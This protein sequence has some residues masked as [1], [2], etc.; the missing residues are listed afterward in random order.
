MELRHLRYFVAVAEEGQ[1]T[2]AARRLCMQQPPLSQQL[3]ELEREIGVVLFRR[4]ARG[5]ELTDAG[6]V[7]LAEA[8]TLLDRLN[9]AVE[10][11]RQAGEGRRGRLALGLTSSSSFHPFVPEVFHAFRE[12]FPDVTLAL[13][14]NGS[15]ELL[16]GLREGRLHVAFVRSRVA[17]ARGIG[18][19]CILEEEMVVALPMGHAL[20]PTHP[21]D[22]QELP[23]E[24]LASE[25]FV[26]Y[27]R[28]SG[29][30]LYDAI[31]AACSRAGFSPNIGQEAPV[32]V[33]TLNLVAA[34]LGVSI[35]PVSLRRQPIEGVAYRR[36]LDRPKLVA[37]LNLAFGETSSPVVREFIDLVLRVREGSSARGEEPASI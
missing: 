21:E 4:H 37:P 8:R 30:G 6:Y 32:T 33:P 17:G 26:L 18:V 9:G 16:R 11:T 7:L 24:A 13:E 5:V 31:I 12:A 15:G 27:R 1:V 3:R 28:P 14:E 20:A 2:R 34:G 22:D 19:H 25:T 35:I 10:L 29:S 23:L 36:I